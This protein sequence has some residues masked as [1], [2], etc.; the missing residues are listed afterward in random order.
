MRQKNLFPTSTWVLEVFL[1]AW[2]YYLTARLSLLLAFEHT[3]ASPFWLPSGLAFAAILLRG[4]RLW[5]GILVG[6]SLSNA[7]GFAANHVGTMPFILTVSF[8]IAVGNTLEAVLGAF[9]FHR[10]IGFHNPLDRLQNTFKFL[11]IIPAMCLA[12]SLVGP[13]VICL[14]KISS[15]ACRKYIRRQVRFA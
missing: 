8:L 15:S 3:N 12:G 1:L 5:P 2:I 13:T 10:F 4:Y 14:S 9:L 11:F 6:A 7:V